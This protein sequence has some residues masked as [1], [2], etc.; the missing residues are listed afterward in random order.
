VA[1]GKPATFHQDGFNALTWVVLKGVVAIPEMGD[2]DEDM[3]EATLDEGR[4]E[5]LAG[6][7]DGGVID[8][9]V[10]FFE[11]DAGQA[12]LLA[13]NPNTGLEEVRAQPTP[14]PWRQVPSLRRYLR[15]SPGLVRRKEEEHVVNRLPDWRRKLELYLRDASTRPFRPRPHDCAL[16]AAGAVKAMTGTD[17]AKGRLRRPHCAGRKHSA[18]NRTDF[19]PGRRYR[20]IF[21]GLTEPAR[22]AR[23]V[24]FTTL[25]GATPNRAATLRQPSPDC[26]AETTRSLRSSA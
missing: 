18:R 7:V 16:S 5:H 19:R 22:R 10:V 26:M 1:L 6:G 11:G 13:R 15:R 2:E 17:L 24:H 14:A 9:P 12:L 25:E 23:S 21:A 3:A 4:T 20:P 8:I